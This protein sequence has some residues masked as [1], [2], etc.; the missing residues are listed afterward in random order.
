[1]F[2]HSPLR[3]YFC[4]VVR[5]G[6]PARCRLE[7]P[8]GFL[9]RE[10]RSRL[11][12]PGSLPQCQSGIPSRRSRRC[13]PPI[14][15]PPEAGEWPR[16]RLT[17]SLIGVGPEPASARL[18]TPLPD[19]GAPFQWLGL[20]FRTRSSHRWRGVLRE[21]QPVVVPVRIR[22][23]RPHSIMKSTNPSTSSPSSPN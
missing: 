11:L 14:E 19:S 17:R 3:A 1:M 8:P 22:P 20:H 6:T 9:S 21:A 10:G 2:R 5:L 13:I 7:A 12:P 15:A 16:S 23:S 18:P 4:R